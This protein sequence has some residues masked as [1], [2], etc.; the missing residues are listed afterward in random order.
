MFENDMT[1]RKELAPIEYPIDVTFA[2]TI[3]PSHVPSIS[4]SMYHV[5]VV[6]MRFPVLAWLPG[7]ITDGKTIMARIA[8][9]IDRMVIMAA[10][11]L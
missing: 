10:T 5:V 2:I 4:V 8:T 6:P 1:Q 11:R 3:V 9:R 7:M